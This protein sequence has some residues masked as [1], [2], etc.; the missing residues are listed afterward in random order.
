MHTHAAVAS[1]PEPLCAYDVAFLSPHLRTDCKLAVPTAVLAVS[2][3][4]AQA[5]YQRTGVSEKY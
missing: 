2:V 1:S 4:A 5:D 3:G